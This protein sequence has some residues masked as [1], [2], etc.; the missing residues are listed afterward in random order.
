[1]NGKVSIWKIKPMDE[2]KFIYQLNQIIKII[3]QATIN[4]L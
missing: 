2:N 3:A 1:M 4:V